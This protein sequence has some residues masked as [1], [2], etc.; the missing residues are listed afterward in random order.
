[1]SFIRYPA[2]PTTPVR[3]SSP[4]TSATASRFSSLLATSL[5]A[6]HLKMSSCTSDSHP[7]WWDR[8][9]RSKV[10]TEAGRWAPNWAYAI[11]HESRM[12]SLVG[13]KASA[14][15]VELG[16]AVDED[17]CFDDGGGV[18]TAV[19]NDREICD[20]SDVEQIESRI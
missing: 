17:A 19:K 20:M 18:G 13:K 15:E 5:S 11:D 9:C 8:W 1:M 6:I 10:E 4:I 14:V 2:Y 16:L 12:S 7:G 3:I